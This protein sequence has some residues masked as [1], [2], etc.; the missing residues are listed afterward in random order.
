MNQSVHF[1]S[2]FLEELS[3]AYRKRR[4]SLSHRASS[5]DL[6][7]TYE[8]VETERMERLEIY[9]PNYDKVVLRLHAW[10]DR[11]IWLDARRSSKQGW[12][13]SWTH[14]GRLLRSHGAKEVIEALEETLDT[15]FEMNSLRT[16]ELSG[17]WNALLAQGPKEVR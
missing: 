8:L 16:Q 1:E 12:V 15:L 10:P 11:S 3:I 17:P 7:K 14:E 9:L 13:W 4:K 6:A 5:A 2:E